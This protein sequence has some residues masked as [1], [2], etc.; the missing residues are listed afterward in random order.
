MSTACTL[1]I[2]ELWR[3]AQTVQWASIYRM[4]L[5]IFLL[6]VGAEVGGDVG[7]AY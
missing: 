5:A 2:Q 4:I 6:T 1:V 3:Q 7:A